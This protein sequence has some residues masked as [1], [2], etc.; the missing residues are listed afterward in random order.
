MRVAQ[1][2][3]VLLHHAHAVEDVELAGSITRGADA[4]QRIL[5]ESEGARGIA[6]LVSRLREGVNGV[7][8]A[9]R[10]AE[11]LIGSA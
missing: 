6:L 11:A 8:R 7:G 4:P 9:R 3:H 5:F 1:A 2:T 10:V